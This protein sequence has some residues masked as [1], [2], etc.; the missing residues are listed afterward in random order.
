M[1]VF[2]EILKY[3][4]AAGPAS[5]AG[6]AGKKALGFGGHLGRA[7]ATGAGAGVAGAA[8]TGAGIAASK[9]Y[10]AMTKT[11]DFRNMMGSSFNSDLQP[12]HQQKPRQFNEAFTSLRS[13]NPAF[14]KDP[15]VA[16]TYMRRM[17]ENV[18][19]AAGGYLIEALHARKDVPE[20]P[21]FE[22]FQRAGGGAAGSMMG[23][24]MRP[25]KVMSPEEMEQQKQLEESKQQI[26]ARFG[27]GGQGV[28]E[29]PPPQMSSRRPPRGG[30]QGGGGPGERRGPGGF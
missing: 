24:L 20:S 1:S 8:V 16:G 7:L 26:R 29:E 12:L 6:E 14:T 5:M 17:M 23:E 11:R 13:M 3:K 19:E 18:P 22:S 4:T 27:K 2:D 21:M 25:P 9:I 30:P 10:D 15:M 28:D